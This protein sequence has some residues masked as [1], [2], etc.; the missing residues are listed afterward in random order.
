MDIKDIEIFWIEESNKAFHTTKVLFKKKK[1]TESMFYL[2]LAV[3]KIIK[4]LFV[5]QMEIEAPFGH[6][7]QNIALKIESVHIP[8][9][10]IDL[11]SEITVFNISTRYDDYKRSFY[12]IC[13]K[14]YAKKY[15]LK[16]EELIKWL[17]SQFK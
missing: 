12:L 8:D 15:I 7:L 17:K 16:A 6:N 2:H 5:N 9:K 13:D 4:G 11:L 3:E 10:I 14:K 1:Y